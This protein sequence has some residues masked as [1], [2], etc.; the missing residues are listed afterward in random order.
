MPG[1]TAEAAVAAGQPY[2]TRAMTSTRSEATILPQQRDPLE[3][4]PL[5]VTPVSFQCPGCYTHSCGFLGLST[6]L[7]CC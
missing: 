1:F 3:T 6:C 4:G 2:R 5:K 7:T